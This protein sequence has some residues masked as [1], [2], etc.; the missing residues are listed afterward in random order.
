MIANEEKGNGTCAK[1][2]QGWSSGESK[3]KQFK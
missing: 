1:D 3:L 2:E